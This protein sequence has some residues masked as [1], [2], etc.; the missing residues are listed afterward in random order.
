MSKGVRDS[1]LVGLHLKSTP[2]GGGNE[3]NRRPG[4]GSWDILWSCPKQG[5]SLLYLNEGQMVKHK[6]Y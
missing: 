3:G 5:V 2:V 6:V 4:Q 1:R